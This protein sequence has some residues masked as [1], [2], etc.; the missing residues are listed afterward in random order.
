MVIR[1]DQ[2]NNMSTFLGKYD[3][4]NRSASCVKFLLIRQVFKE[5]LIILKLL[6][7]TVFFISYKIQI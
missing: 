7:E 6:L 5:Y 1:F 3:I 4:N 2:S